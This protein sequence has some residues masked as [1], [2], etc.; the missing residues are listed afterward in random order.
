MQFLSRFLFLTDWLTSF[1]FF[2]LSWFSYN[3]INFV[4]FQLS[5]H[6]KAIASI[7]IFF[8]L[9]LPKDG[10]EYFQ[11]VV[12]LFCLRCSLHPLHHHANLHQE[13]FIFKASWKKNGRFHYTIRYYYLFSKIILLL[14]LKRCLLTLQFQNIKD[15][16]N[17][18][19][20]SLYYFQKG[21]TLQFSLLHKLRLNYVFIMN[22]I[23]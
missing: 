15:K 21:I 6:R 8:K 22:K 17:P 4:S 23:I 20:L 7:F 19:L 12:T 16:L 10:H 2:F 14:G 9:L 18:Y 11:D 3:F 5:Q 1:S 13:V